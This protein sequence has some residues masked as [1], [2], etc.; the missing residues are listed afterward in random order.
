M[1]FDPAVHVPIED[2]KVAEVINPALQA[3]PSDGSTQWSARSLAAETG[4]SKST[5][6]RWFKAFSLQLHRQKN[7]RSAEA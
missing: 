4:I 6:H 5:V 7:Y 3:K 2:D 1:K